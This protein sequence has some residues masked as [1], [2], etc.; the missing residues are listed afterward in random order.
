MR[1][2]GILTTIGWN[3]NDWK[4]HPTEEDIS[5]SNFQFVKDNNLM[6]ESLNFAHLVLPTEESGH[7]VGYAPQLTS[8]DRGH[9]RN[10]D[11]VFMR[12]R[13]YVHNK[14][15]IV[16]MYAFPELAN[17]RNPSHPGEHIP[18][19]DERFVRN[20]QLDDEEFGQYGWGNIIAN[21][22]FIVYLD[23][24]EYIND[25]ITS[26]RSFLPKGKKLGHQGY[27]YLEDHNVK[28]LLDAMTPNNK[29]CKNFNRVKM[30]YL[31]KNS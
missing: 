13:D 26:G 25:E 10:L 8:V 12:S 21:P 1:I 14:S 29:G 5:H 9:Q 28:N 4:S 20:T 24:P 19:P 11:V 23:V 31:T 7:Y 30:E 17:V 22:E 15:Y 27:N 2:R 6:F 18:L 3:S 16:G